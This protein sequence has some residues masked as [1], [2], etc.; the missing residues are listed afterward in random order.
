MSAATGRPAESMCCMCMS[1]ECACACECSPRPPAPAHC[2]MPLECPGP[3]PLPPVAHCV[4]CCI[5]HA[6]HGRPDE[7]APIAIELANLHQEHNKSPVQYKTQCNSV[8]F[9]LDSFK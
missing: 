3:D 5:R 4:C 8:H 1:D 9:L 2:C 7:V 6:T